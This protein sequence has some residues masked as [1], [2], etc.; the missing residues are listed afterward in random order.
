[1][2]LNSSVG[3]V[4]LSFSRLSQYHRLEEGRFRVKVR[5]SCAAGVQL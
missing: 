3:V 4:S 5:G 2:F 1:M